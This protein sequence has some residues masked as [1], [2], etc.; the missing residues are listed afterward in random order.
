MRFYPASFR[1]CLRTG[2]LLTPEGSL[3]CGGDQHRLRVISAPISPTKAE[4]NY[5][6]EALVA[7]VARRIWS[8]D[9]RPCGSRPLYRERSETH[10]RDT[11]AVQIRTPLSPWSLHS[12]PGYHLNTTEQRA[13]GP[14]RLSLHGYSHAFN[15]KGPS[16]CRSHSLNFRCMCLAGLRC[17]R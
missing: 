12:L 10:S 9:L 15:D 4:R 13:F 7:Q 3:L 8:G 14:R 1:H 5:R 6:S 11:Y 16:S 2:L 17:V